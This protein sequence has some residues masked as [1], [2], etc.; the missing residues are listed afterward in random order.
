MSSSTTQDTGLPMRP[1]AMWAGTKELV[2]TSLHACCPYGAEESTTQSNNQ[3]S[4]RSL[5]LTPLLLTQDSSLNE[6]IPQ[7]ASTDAA[8]HAYPTMPTTLWQSRLA[9]R[10]PHK[11]RP[12][13]R[14]KFIQRSHQEESSSRY[15][16]RT[17]PSRRKKLHPAAQPRC[18]MDRA[19]HHSA[20]HAAQQRSAPKLYQSPQ[21][22]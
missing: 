20:E 7:Q 8:D 21:I 2:R 1:A 14:P 4:L 16:K 13:S 3:F 18:L 19:L 6:S 5:I 10:N 9:N 12:P 11:N 22:I 15:D 17:W